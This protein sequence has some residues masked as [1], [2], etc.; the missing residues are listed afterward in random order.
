ML[1]R[2]HPPCA[3]HQDRWSARI[4]SRGSGARPGPAVCINGRLAA[5]TWSRPQGL[6]SEPPGGHTR[7]VAQ[8]PVTGWLSSWACVLSGSLAVAGP[9][10]AAW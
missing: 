7:R 9:A 4:P 1:A 6:I 2:L 5:T 10:L 3:D 8:Q